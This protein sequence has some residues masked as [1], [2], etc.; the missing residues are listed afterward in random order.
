MCIASAAAAAGLFAAPATGGTSLAVTLGAAS[1]DLA[2]L[3][4][5]MQFLSAQ[6]QGKAAKG[7]ADYQSAVARNN[8]IIA[9]RKADDARERGKIDAANND[10]RTKQRISQSTVTGAATGQV[11][12]QDS[13]LEITSDT[14][15]LGKLDSLR[16]INNSEREAHGFEVQGVNF[17]SEARL[18]DFKG[19]NA[20]AAANTKAAGSL[21]SGV[22]SVAGKW[23]QFDQDGVFANKS[24]PYTDI[25]GS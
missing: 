21:V 1:L 18:S 2:L 13:N 6:Q 10:L 25:W 14:A 8:Q 7:Q 16:I 24:N 23:Y 19:K 3:G 20:V 15:A 5:G 11:V 9:N 4:T 17:E 22:G 12:D